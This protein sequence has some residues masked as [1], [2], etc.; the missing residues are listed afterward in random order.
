MAATT[1]T[2]DD[3]AA[4][5]LFMG[6][7]CRAVGA[8]FLDWLAPPK[9]AHWL[10]VGCGTGIFTELVVD[11]CA[12]AAVVAVDP[13]AA[14]IGH[15][16]GRPVGQRADFSVAD[17]QT[18][19]FPDGAFEVI[20]SALVMNFIPD[21]SQAL[22]EMR[23]VARPAGVVAGYVWD[24]AAEGSP[25][26]PIRLGMR[27]IGVEPP[28]TPGTEDSTL[29]ALEALFERAEFEQIRTKT[30]DVKETFSDFDEFWRSQAPSFSPTT[31]MIAGLP[32]SDRARLIESV[33]AA[34]PAGPNGSIAYS[35]R[36]NAIKAR[37]PR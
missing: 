4:Y 28:R 36:A 14:Q 18:L 35:A 30:I 21:R 2:F 25:G 31:K 19:P 5:E 1:F 26:S 9:G 37:A 13:S 12:P 11:T 17:A 16:R 24:F 22:A 20:T 27:K 33:R 15:A 6:R 3:G 8:V 34:L 32:E 29:K 10:D 23:R 7:W